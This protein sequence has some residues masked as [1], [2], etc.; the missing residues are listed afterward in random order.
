[1]YKKRKCDNVTSKLL[2]SETNKEFLMLLFCYSKDV[3]VFDS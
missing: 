1:M 3:N 2:V